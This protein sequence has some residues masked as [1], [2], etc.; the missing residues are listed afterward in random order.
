MIIKVQNDLDGVGVLVTRAERQ[1]GPLSRL[2]ANHGGRPVRFPAMK[3]CGPRDPGP[4][5]A[6]LDDLENFQIAIF[7]SPN[8][9]WFGL[10][11]CDL[12]TGI[13]IGAVGKGTAL[14]LEQA[15]LTVDIVP[16]ERSDSEALLS[17]QELKAA[18]GSRIVIF[19]GNGGRPMLGDILRQRGAEVVY[20]EAYRRVCPKMDATA[21]IES[22]PREIQIVT[23]TSID[24]LNNLITMLGS[25]GLEHLRQTPLI[26]ISERMC[27][28]ARNIGCKHIIFAEGAG[29]QKLLLAVSEW[30]RSRTIEA[31]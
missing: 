22:W 16:E 11:L 6:I 15:G 9:V 25:D 19:R 30:A 10:S 20:A 4:V 23:A 3:I 27:I 7:I 18:R 26:V 17:T 12:P 2:I 13:K 31:V 1:A 14:A 8:A 28:L 21:L 29:D 5:N 24:L